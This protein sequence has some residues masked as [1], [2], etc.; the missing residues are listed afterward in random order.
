MKKKNIE[1]I[2]VRNG[3]D[4]FLF[5]QEKGLVVRTFGPCQEMNDSYIT[6]V[7]RGNPIDKKDILFQKSY[8]EREDALKG[9]TKVVRDVRLQP[10]KYIDRKESLFA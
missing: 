5:V 7:L 1:S 10:Y 3:W 6:N 2:F 9:H 4:V 8:R